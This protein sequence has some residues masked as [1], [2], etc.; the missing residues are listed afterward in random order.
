MTTRPIRGLAA[1]VLTTSALAFAPLAAQAAPHA[2]M[3]GVTAPTMTQGQLLQVRHGR[4][5]DDGANHDVGDDKGGLRG[6]RGR[7][8]DDRPGKARGDDKGG[9]RGGKG[10][11]RD[12]GPNHT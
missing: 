11:G 1:T 8:A 6:G 5:A 3:R 7:G 12:D 9:R 10:R 2:V 4:G